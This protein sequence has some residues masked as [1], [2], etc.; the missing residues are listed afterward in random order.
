MQLFRIF[1][2]HLLNNGT[3]EVMKLLAFF[4]VMHNN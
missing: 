3:S 2:N 4:N 1:R